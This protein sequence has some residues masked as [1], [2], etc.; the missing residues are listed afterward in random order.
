MRG[1]RSAEYASYIRSAAWFRK[2]EWWLEE[3]RARY[4]RLQV[5]CYGCSRPWSL[6]DD[7]HHNSYEHFG[8]ERFE[9]LWPLCRACH[10]LLHAELEPLRRWRGVRFAQANVM[11]LRRV[12]AEQL[13]EDTGSKH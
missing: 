1:V 12:R 8:S 5:Q 11:A 6:R 4:P 3:C 10:E 2:R 13:G 7:L 9:D